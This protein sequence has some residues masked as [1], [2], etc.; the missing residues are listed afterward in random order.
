LAAFYMLFRVYQPDIEALNGQYKEMYG[1]FDVF[2][3]D[4][5]IE[6]QVKLSGQYFHRE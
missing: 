4:Q 5:L 6:R 1:C 3:L 2:L